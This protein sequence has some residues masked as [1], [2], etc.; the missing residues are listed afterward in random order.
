MT[1]HPPPFFPSTFS[2]QFFWEFS[3]T[4]IRKLCRFPFPSISQKIIFPG[5]KKNTELTQRK[6]IP[7]VFS[8]RQPPLDAF[9]G[10]VL[11]H[12]RVDRRLRP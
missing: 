10:R 11:A 5:L 4:Q 6:N 2:R 8:F 7:T 12:H 3:G 9:F 1:P